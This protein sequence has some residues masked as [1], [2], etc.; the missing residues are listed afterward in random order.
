[1]STTKEITN[2]NQVSNV[3]LMKEIKIEQNFANQAY[4]NFKSVK[5]G[6]EACCYTDFVSA[7][8]KK[9]ICDWQN[10]ISNKLVVAT[11]T[12]GVFVEPLAKVNLKASVS[13]PETPT[14][15]CTILD[16]EEIIEDTGTYTQCFENA[17]SVWTVT[18]N[19]GSF[20][21]VTVVDSANTVVVG[22]VDYISSQQ[23]RITFAAS[24]SGCVFLN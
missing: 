16:L 3:A 19:L 6:I 1:M 23:L 8:L 20:P 12:P 15:V 14:S 5:F 2:A 10:S 11:E 18:H 9:D 21:S 4:A 22:D 7:T 24:F 13:C 17:S